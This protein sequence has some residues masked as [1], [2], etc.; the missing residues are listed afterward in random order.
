[1][2]LCHTPASLQGGELLLATSNSATR[3]LSQAGQP[4]PLHTKNATA[5]FA[6]D[7]TAMEASQLRRLLQKN[8]FMFSRDMEVRPVVGG[9]SRTA[10]PY[11]RQQVSSLAPAV[12]NSSPLSCDY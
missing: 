11:T 6:M 12:G 3:R 5:E 4:T 8:Q 9:D 1:V 2:L 7:G 10:G